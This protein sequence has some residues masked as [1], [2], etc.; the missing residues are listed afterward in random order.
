MVEKET[1][2]L[3][4]EVG[5]EGGYIFGSGEMIPRDTPEGNIKAMVRRKRNFSD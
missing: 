1:R 2:R 3:I 5:K 4:E